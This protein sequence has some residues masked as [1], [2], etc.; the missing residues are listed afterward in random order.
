ML[1]EY[2]NKAQK[3]LQ[4][5]HELSKIFDN[6]LILV[7]KLSNSVVIVAEQ[8]SKTNFW[9]EMMQR[10]LTVHYRMLKTFRQKFLAVS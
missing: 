1:N 2:D 9:S 10:T 7:L 5:T 4:V 3:K 6:E 8:H